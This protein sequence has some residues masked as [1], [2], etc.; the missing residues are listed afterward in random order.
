MRIRLGRRVE[1]LTRELEGTRRRLGPG[2]GLC[3][4]KVPRGCAPPRQSDSEV[5]DT[6]RNFFQL[7]ISEC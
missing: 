7:S 6:R 3:P 2:T 4:S 5:G 1:A